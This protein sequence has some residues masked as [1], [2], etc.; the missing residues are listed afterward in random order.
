MSDNTNQPREYDAVLG[1]KNIPS[2][3]GAVVLGGIEGVKLRLKNADPKVRIAGLWQ[4]LNYGEQGLDLVIQGLNNEFVEVQKQAYLL[5]N[6]RTETRV[7]QVLIESDVHLRLGGI[8][9]YTRLRDFLADGKWREADKETWRVMFTVAKRQKERWLR[10]EDIQNFPCEDLRT[11]D[12]LW[13]KYSNGHFGFSV[14]QRIFHSLGVTRE[15]NYKIWGEFGL[16]IGWKQ[17][18]LW[19]YYREISFDIKAPKGHLPASI[20][21]CY[22]RYSGGYDYETAQFVAFISSRLVNCDI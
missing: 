19:L 16:Q 13:V 18:H 20:D 11:I 2:L 6:T 3:E 12:D 22:E 15:S 17:R 10:E 4:A 8:T 7:Q 21:I 14:Q 5:L 9:D 1:G